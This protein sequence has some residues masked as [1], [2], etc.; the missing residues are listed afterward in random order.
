MAY[1]TIMG[2][3]DTS[4]AKLAR[5]IV[6]RIRA[7][8]AKAYLVGGCVRDLLLGREPKDYDV[9]TDARPDQILGLFPDAKQV[10]AHFGVMLVR[11]EDTEVE[12]A[13]FRSE[14]S[15]EDGRHPGHVAFETDPHQDV[16]R[17]DF[18]INALLLDPESGEVL[19]FTG[20][21]S[22]L[23]A[24][25]V[26]AIGNP[27][28]RFGE[29]H[30]R[31]LRAVRFASTLGFTVEPETMR[32]IRR[33]APSIRIV[34]AE[35]SRDELTRI[36]TEGAA[37][38][39][40]ELLDES[41]LLLELLPE[42][43]SMKEVKQPKEFHPE[44]DVWTHTL[45]MLGLLQRPSATLALGVL[46]HDVGKPPTFRVRERIRFDGHSALGAKMAVG[47]MSRLRF[48]NQE[49]KI[50]EALVADHLRFK[51]V[52]QMRE[53]TLRR[54]LRQPYFD[55]LLEL[56][57]LDC[58]AS[59]GWLDNYEFVRSKQRELP[60]ARLRPPR[61]VTGRDLIR[62]GYTPGPVF[63][64][65]LEAVEDAQLES[66]VRTQDE[67]MDLLRGLFGEPPAIQTGL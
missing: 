59:H 43:A 62:A 44:G 34:S 33:M 49:I 35:R 17:R 53:S 55:E 67:A 16:L 3:G 31:M 5:S 11:R 8:G 9:A 36:L 7:H 47:I 66:R 24:G 13:T 54:F 26:R 19:D 50:V 52:G 23:D 10:G 6:G 58:L 2:A 65:M 61:L 14:H 32:A 48:S 1:S 42:V 4:A 22:D 56:H 12:I 25:V 29:D 64:R 57:R 45:L 20:G 63:A 46:L 21:R 18:T 40:A 38:R 60:P 37:R 15:Y 41:N 28:S 30:L 27:E 39:G 51:D